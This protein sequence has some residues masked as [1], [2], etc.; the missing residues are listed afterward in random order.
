[1]IAALAQDNAIGKDNDLLWKPWELRDDMN[2]F[3]YKTHG[4][5]VIMGRKTWESIPEK[6][7]PLPDRM[8]I[9]ITRNND[10]HI[11]LNQQEE[12]VRLGDGL[13][14]H[15]CNSLE[16]AIDLAKGENHSITWIIGGAE[17]YKLGLELADELHLTNVFYRADDPDTFFPEYKNKYQI[18]VDSVPKIYPAQ[19]GVNKYA[20]RFETWKRTI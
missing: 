16:D 5:A 10:Y 6:Y 8:N 7:R 17:I 15:I 12:D 14:T 3:K 4:H 11:S 9:V 19:K 18:M 20:F 2:N 13:G 1:M